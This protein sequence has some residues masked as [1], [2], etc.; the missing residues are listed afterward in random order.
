MYMPFAFLLASVVAA[1]SA[2]SYA[3]MSSRYPKSA[4]EAIYVNEAF[5]IKFLS[6]FVGWAIVVVG[7][8]S[9]AT[10]ANG[11]VGYVDIFINVP[12]WII[13]ISIILILYLI[14]TRGVKE[15]VAFASVITIIE[16]IGLLIIIYSGFDNLTEI[17]S[18]WRELIPPINYDI[19]SAIILGAY[20]AFY[21]FIGFEDMVNMAE[22]VKNPEI[23]LP[24]SIIIVLIV[25]TILYFLVAVV[26]VFSI[27]SRTAFRQ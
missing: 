17:N 22:E 26:A 5:G 2:L 1:F 24:K 15:S 20:I 8:V 23:N 12:S 18:R 25:S 21:A 16:I 11:I 10:L 13:K 19:F 9:V 14:A 4:G 7:I 6:A 3:E 27:T